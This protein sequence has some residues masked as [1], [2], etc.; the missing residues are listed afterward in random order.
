[1]GLR[2]RAAV[3]FQIPVA[4]TG[5]VDFV[6]VSFGNWIIWNLNHSCLL[7][8]EAEFHNSTQLQ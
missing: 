2:A 1:M 8:S 5:G 6:I 3:T 7:A 4:T